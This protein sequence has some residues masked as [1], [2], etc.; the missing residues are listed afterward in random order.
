MDYVSPEGPVYQAGTLSGNPVAMSAGYAILSYLN[1]HNEVYD[2]IE[3][4]TN[5]IVRGISSNLKQLN[6]NY[7]INQVGSMFSLFFSPEKITDFNLAKRCDT[8]KFGAYFKLMLDQGIYLA[9]SQFEALFVSSAIDEEE[10]EKTIRAN[11]ASL[12]SLI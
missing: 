7:T 8:E 4:T 2:Q 1:D 3:D 9:P 6:L 11:Y 10:I 5:K 12:K